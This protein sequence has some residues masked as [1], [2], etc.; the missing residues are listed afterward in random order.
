MLRKWQVI[1]VCPSDDTDHDGFVGKNL[2]Q[3]LRISTPPIVPAYYL[4][5]TPNHH[6][7]PGRH[8]S[9]IGNFAPGFRRRSFIEGDHNSGI[10]VQP[11]LFGSRGPEVKPGCF[12]G[13][14]VACG[15]EEQ[16]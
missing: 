2:I 1:S 8:V 6:L 16:G 4:P 7:G 3:P 9:D 14:R 5:G 10:Q 13:G 15:Q 11:V 12:K